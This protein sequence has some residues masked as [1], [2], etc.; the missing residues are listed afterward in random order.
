M[1]INLGVVYSLRK[2]ICNHYPRLLQLFY[3]YTW[4]LPNVFSSFWLPRDNFHIS[5]C[6]IMSKPTKFDC[7]KF[8]NLSIS[9]SY[10]NQ[11]HTFERIRFPFDKVNS[12]IDKFHAEWQLFKSVFSMKD[13]LNPM[14]A[15]KIRFLATMVCLLCFLYSENFDE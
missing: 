7:L 9:I 1:N 6:D 8:D 11:I 3:K 4:D 12:D 5:L 10:K 14:K 13:I 15:S 2:Q